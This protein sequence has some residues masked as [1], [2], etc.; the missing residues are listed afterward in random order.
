M[1]QQVNFRCEHKCLDKSINIID[2]VSKIRP[3]AWWSYHDQEYNSPNG[4]SLY[5]YPMN[6]GKLVKDKTD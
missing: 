5:R 3:E 6:C 1:G 4:L 2:K